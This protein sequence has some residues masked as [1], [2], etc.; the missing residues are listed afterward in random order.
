MIHFDDLRFA[1]NGEH[2][3]TFYLIHSSSSRVDIEKR[4]VQH[5]RVS[6]KQKKKEE[7][8]KHAPDR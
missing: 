7:N 3:Q 4:R 1:K 6:D 5:D 2:K 8:N